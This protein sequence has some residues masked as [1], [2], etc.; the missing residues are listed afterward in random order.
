MPAVWFLWSEPRT[1]TNSSKGAN[2]QDFVWFESN[3]FGVKALI[4]E[5]RFDRFCCSHDITCSSLFF[6]FTW[7]QTGTVWE[8]LPAWELKTHLFNNYFTSPSS[9][10]SSSILT[11]YLA[12]A[13]I[14]PDSNVFIYLFIIHE[15]SWCIAMVTRWCFSLLQSLLLVASD[16]RW[17]VKFDFFSSLTKLSPVRQRHALRRSTWS[18]LWTLEAFVTVSVGPGSANQSP[19]QTR[20][21]PESIW[22]TVCT[23]MKV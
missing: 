9:L 19:I 11:A 7:R 1:R 18:S 20:L 10:P 13:Y 14:L 4:E 15:P 17:S 2:A 5:I 21:A 22:S 8:A 12:S 6:V 3:R 23:V 16:I